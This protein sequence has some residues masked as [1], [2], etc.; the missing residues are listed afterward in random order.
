LA[1]L[2]ILSLAV[3]RSFDSHVFTG[4]WFV[5]DE[6]GERGWVPGVYL[7]K[8]DGSQENLVT[9]ESELGQGERFI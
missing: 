1:F 5:S 8:Q 9:K 7:E 6:E 3:H 4:W 2:T